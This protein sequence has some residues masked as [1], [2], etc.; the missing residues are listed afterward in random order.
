MAI[1]M[2]WIKKYFLSTN[3]KNT[4]IIYFIFGGFAGIIG[5]FLLKLQLYNNIIIILFFILLLLLFFYVFLL[6]PYYFIFSVIYLGFFFAI[7]C[8][9]STLKV[10][11][12][13]LVAEYKFKT[14]SIILGYILKEGKV[15]LY[16]S[17]KIIFD[18]QKY[19]SRLNLQLFN[20]YY[21]SFCSD[22]E[23]NS[24]IVTSRIRFGSTNRPKFFILDADGIILFLKKYKVHICLISLKNLIVASDALLLSYNLEIYT[25]LLTHYLF[26]T[27]KKTKIITI[28]NMTRN[29]LYSTNLAYILKLKNGK[30]HIG[31]CFNQLFIWRLDQ[32]DYFNENFI[33]IYAIF[34]IKLESDTISGLQSHV[35]ESYLFSM[36][37]QIME[38]HICVVSRHLNGI[39][40]SA[41]DVDIL[42]IVSTIFGD[43]N[44]TWGN[45][46]KPINPLYFQGITPGSLHNY[47]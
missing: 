36:T 24:F 9:D 3:H 22:L 30:W 44:V 20:Y 41:S 45:V 37:S 12:C 38:V 33:C 18:L 35:L 11:F 34:Q 5:T 23:N 27:L 47:K 39:H 26:E 2:N 1:W 29:V 13:K 28:F 10:E 21:E 25:T 16:F 19:D 42:Y 14:L 15:Q 8:L 43:K 4:L 40:F 46:L 6:F 32:H 31:M 7:F 17:A